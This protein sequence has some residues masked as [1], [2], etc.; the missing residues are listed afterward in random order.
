MS[1]VSDFEVGDRVYALVS[2]DAAEA[3]LLGFG[4]YEGRH[5]HP[6]YGVYNPRIRL[7][8]GETV[9]GLEC[10]WG[11]AEHFDAVVGGRAVIEAPRP[12]ETPE[13]TEAE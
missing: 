11:L 6:D 5:L 2:M 10:W 7:D 8:N 1:A 4:E 12:E 3:W 13:S 9:W